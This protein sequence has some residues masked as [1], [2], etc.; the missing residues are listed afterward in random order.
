MGALPR[1][2]RQVSRGPHRFLINGASFSF[3]PLSVVFCPF[4][5]VTPSREGSAPTARTRTSAD[6]EGFDARRRPTVRLHDS[7]RR[8]RRGSRG[9]VRRSTAARQQ[10]GGRSGHAR[11]PIAN[12]RSPSAVGVPR[13][14]TSIPI[15]NRIGQIDSEHSLDAS[16]NCVLA[17]VHGP[18]PGRSDPPSSSRARTDRPRQEHVAILRSLDRA[19]AL[20]GSGA[21]PTMGSY[22]ERR[23]PADRPAPLPAGRADRAREMA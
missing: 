8:A 16:E 20:R 11:E 6:V 10:M 17:L 14:S 4:Y 7:R 15:P 3:C 18:G 23:A 12:S 5:V 2:R 1:Q 9:S 22:R 19:D 21:C 13:R